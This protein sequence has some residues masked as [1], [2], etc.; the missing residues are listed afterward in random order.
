MVLVLVQ[1]IFRYLEPF[2]RDSFTRATNGQTEGQT[3]SWKIP[4]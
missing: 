3:L 4:R 2:R 1:S